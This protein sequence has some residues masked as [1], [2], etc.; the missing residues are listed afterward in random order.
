MEHE[1]DASRIHHRW[2]SALEPT[3]RVEPGQSTFAMQLKARELFPRL[4]QP[5]ELQLKQVAG[6]GESGPTYERND[7]PGTVHSYL[8]EI[9]E[10]DPDREA[11][12]AM[13]DQLLEAVS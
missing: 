1:I 2:D 3:L 9:L 6:N 12:L 11:L 8:N 4:C 5:I 10:N 13:A 7:V